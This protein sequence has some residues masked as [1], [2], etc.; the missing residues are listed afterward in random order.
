MW[1]WLASL[2]LVFATWNPSGH[3]WLHWVLGSLSASQLG[4]IHFLT[5]AVLVAGWAIFMVATRRSLGNMGM[6]I[7]LLLVG[8]FLWFLSEIGLLR[9]Q[10]ATAVIWLAQFALATLL[11]VGLSWSLIWRRLSGQLE[12]DDS[13]G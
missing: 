7:V 3:S 1:R 2:V 11:A 6:I 5:G 13:D 10:S 8:C 4:A 12:V 9:A